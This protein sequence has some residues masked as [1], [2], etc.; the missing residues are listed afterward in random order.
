MAQFDYTGEAEL[1]APK[2]RSTRRQQPSYRRF[3]RAAE[4]VRAAIEETP[5]SLIHSTYLVAR[6]ERYDSH[7]IRRLYENAHYPFKRSEYLPDD[8]LSADQTSSST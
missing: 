4:A 3:V 6:G 8:A 7:A 1:F 5:P 2:N